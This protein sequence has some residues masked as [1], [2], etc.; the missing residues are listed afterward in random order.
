LDVNITINST[1][2]ASNSFPKRQLNE[3]VLSST[4]R[5]SP[6]LVVPVRLRSKMQISLMLMLGA[7]TDE[8]VVQS[9]AVRCVAVRTQRHWALK[10]LKDD[11][12]ADNDAE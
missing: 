7:A 12:D 9:E 5:A 10:K 6:L 1:T 8:C 2:T 3:G 11:D 4:T